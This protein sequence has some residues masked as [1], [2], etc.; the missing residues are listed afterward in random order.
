M[1]DWQNDSANDTDRGAHGAPAPA[2][3][4]AAL[5]G[6]PHR[7]RR[8]YVPLGRVLATPGA[9]RTLALAGANGAVYLARHAAGDW[10]D[11][12]AHDWAANDR[13]LLIDERLLSA[14]QLPNGERLWIITEADRSASTLLLPDEY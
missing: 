5:E 11:V 14:Y 10:G 4:D 6:A 8:A 2:S 13:A 9:L 1:I 12:D 3:G 7:R